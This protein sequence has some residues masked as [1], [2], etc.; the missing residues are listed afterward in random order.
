[1]PGRN[2]VPSPSCTRSW[3]VVTFGGENYFGLSGNSGGIGVSLV[4]L[5]YHF[6][7]HS[8]RVCKIMTSAIFNGEYLP[9]VKQ[10]IL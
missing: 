6:G 7:S 5:G 2:V 10:K 9:G 1:L 4:D 8:G 3:I